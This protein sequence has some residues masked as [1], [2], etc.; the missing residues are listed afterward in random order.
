[1]QLLS[2]LKKHTQLQEQSIK[3]TVELLNEDCTVPFI[4]RYRK[5]KTGNLD[6][7]QI[8]NIVQFKLQFEALQKRKVAI[9]KAIEEQNAFTEELRQKINSSQD[10]VTL[11]DIYLPYKK[12][13]KTK[14]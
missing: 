8:G 5:E 12:K 14:A 10:L 11:E 13:R 2:Y 3:N 1:M 6:E 4:S 9:I 7:V